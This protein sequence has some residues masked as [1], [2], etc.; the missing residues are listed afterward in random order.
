LIDDS[1]WKSKKLAFFGCGLMGSGVAQG[2]AI[3]AQ[4]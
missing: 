1:E 2:C 4:R 3:G